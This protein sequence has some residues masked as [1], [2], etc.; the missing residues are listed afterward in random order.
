MPYYYTVTKDTS[1]YFVLYNLI[2][3]YSRKY[4]SVDDLYEQLK[5]YEKYIDKYN[6]KKYLISLYREGRLNRKN[7]QYIVALQSCGAEGAQ[8]S[9]K[10]KVV[11]SN[12][13]TTTK[14][15]YKMEKS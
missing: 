11:G 6:I 4:F 7:N 12:P 15:K 1:D 3:S 14:K 10:V 5:S 2:F 9:Y 8:D 13:I